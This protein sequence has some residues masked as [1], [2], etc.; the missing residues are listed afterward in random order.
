MDEAFWQ[1]KWQRGEIGFHAAAPNPL[2]TRNL[3]ALGLA[4]GARL[5][6]PLCG[7]SL[8]I[9]WLLAQ[10]HAVAGAELSRLAVEQ[11][12]SELGVEPTIRAAGT[13]ERFEAEGL[14]IFVGN[15]FD[16]DAARL[17]PVDAIY[18]RAALVALPETL[19]TLYAAH[20][21]A[22]TGGAAQ[23]LVTYQYDQS[24]MSGPPF[25]VGPAEVGRHY[26]ALYRLTLLEEAQVE[27]GLRG[28][29]ARES[30]WH[31]APR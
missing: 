22:L 3:P 9:H 17:E 26:D 29:P 20:L 27:G 4:P 25:S 6:L 24:R 30:V 15:I 10:G 13:L 28:E 12:F 23:M 21:V 14:T 19:R 11:L 8:D 7:K 16:L 18:D 31:L 2:L 5:F 1:G